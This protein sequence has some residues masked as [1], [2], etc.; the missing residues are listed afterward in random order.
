MDLRLSRD[1]FPLELLIN[2]VTFNS[3]NVTEQDTIKIMGV[4]PAG[5]HKQ[6]SP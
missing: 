1:V 2:E 3:V 5:G 4:L 6:A